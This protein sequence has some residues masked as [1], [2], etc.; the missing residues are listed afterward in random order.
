MKNG[1][2]LRKEPATGV[3][4][5][6]EFSLVFMLMDALLDDGIPVLTA[7]SRRV[8]TEHTQEDGTVVKTARFDFACFRP[9][10]RLKP[11]D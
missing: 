8:T 6:G 9:Y 3:L 7:A 1:S 2:R 11:R 10:R 5:M 4:F